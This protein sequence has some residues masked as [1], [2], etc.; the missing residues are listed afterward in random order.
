M[1]RW[2]L[3]KSIESKAQVLDRGFHLVALKKLKSEFSMTYIKKIMNMPIKKVSVIIKLVMKESQFLTKNG[4]GC[5]K[6]PACILTSFDD[7]AVCPPDAG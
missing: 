6:S 4:L 5:I 3:L 2:Q 7:N 1:L